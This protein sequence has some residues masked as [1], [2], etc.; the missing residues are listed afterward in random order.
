PGARAWGS[1]VRLGSMTD[2]VLASASPR[3]RELLAGLGLK[4]RL[5]P[6][7]IDETVLPD[8][9]PEALVARLAAGQAA[10]AATDNHAALVIAAD[11]VV[12][13]GGQVLGK[14]R[15][16]AENLEYIARLAGVTHDVFSGHALR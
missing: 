3:R 2:I 4:P 11:T 10:R 7:D 14:P 16:E 1:P 8:E 13:L 15:D 9:R 6:A 12:V 5:E